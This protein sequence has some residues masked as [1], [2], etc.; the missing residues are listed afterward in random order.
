MSRLLHITFT[1]HPRALAWRSAAR[2]LG[3]GA[4]RAELGAREAHGVVLAP[5]PAPRDR[6]EL[7]ARDPDP[8]RPGRELPVAHDLLEGAVHQ[9]EHLGAA[10]VRRRGHGGEQRARRRAA[11][12]DDEKQVAAAALCELAARY[13]ASA[14][15]RAKGKGAKAKGAVAEI[16]A[17]HARQNKGESDMAFRTFRREAIAVLD[18]L[19]S[20]RSSRTRM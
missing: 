7:P 6:R 11:S 16:K 18:D 4:A 2:V 1:L 17:A 12:S 20:P 10:R 5:H 8:E 9:R 3:L 15:S 19:P 13:R 14:P